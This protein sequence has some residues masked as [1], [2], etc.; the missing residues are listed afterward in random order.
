MRWGGAPYNIMHSQDVPPKHS[1]HDEGAKKKFTNVDSKKRSPPEGCR[2]SARDNTYLVCLACITP[3]EEH[4]SGNQKHFLSEGRSLL[5]FG[6]AYDGSG[7]SLCSEISDSSD[8]STDSLLSGST[9]SLFSGSM[10]S[11]QRDVIRDNPNLKLYYR[12][13]NEQKLK[14]VVYYI[15]RRIKKNRNYRKILD[16]AKKIW[17][18]KPMKV[19]RFVFPFLP[20]IA[21]IVASITTLCIGLN[22]Q[23]ILIAIFA[24]Y[25]YPLIFISLRMDK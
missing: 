25:V 5:S 15:S 7:D 19:L 8:G 13:A 4:H 24:P 6:T 17:K 21:M 22:V 3:N 2:K 11:L 14:E 23:A 20:V 16:K 10:D 1:R 18:T 12:I 9:D